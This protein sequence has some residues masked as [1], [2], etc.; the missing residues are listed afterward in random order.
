MPQQHDVLLTNVP[1]LERAGRDADINEQVGK[2][3]AQIGNGVTAIGRSTDRHVYFVDTKGFLPV[4]NDGSTKRTYTDLKSANLLHWSWVMVEDMEQL[5]NQLLEAAEE[6]KRQT[7]ENEERE[8]QGLPP[9]HKKRKRLDGLIRLFPTTPTTKFPEETVLDR[10]FP[11]VD[12]QHH[13]QLAECANKWLDVR[14]RTLNSFLDTTFYHPTHL[15]R[16][17]AVMPY[18]ERANGGIGNSLC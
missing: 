6:D 2:S 5:N 12:V 7:E 4:E 10:K 17:P 1:S 14:L 8:R 18:R 13:G 9:K 15:I 3:R 16:D 11:D